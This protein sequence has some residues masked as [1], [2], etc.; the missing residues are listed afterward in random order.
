M[1]KTCADAQRRLKRLKKTAKIMLTEI[2]MSRGFSKTNSK[3]CANYVMKN[4]C[5]TNVKII[6]KYASISVLH[7]YLSLDGKLSGIDRN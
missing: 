7:S 2:I 6:V 1:R 5:N 3:R 4:K